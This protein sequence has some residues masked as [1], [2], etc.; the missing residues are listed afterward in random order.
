MVDFGYNRECFFFMIDPVKFATT[1]SDPA[2][3]DKLIEESLDVLYSIPVSASSRELLKKNMLLTGQEQN[4]YWTDAWNDL[5][6]NPGD[7][8]KRNIVETRLK[9]LY[10]F[11]LSS[12]EYQLA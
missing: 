8:S 2:D 1:L 11:M 7:Q 5:A 12:P 9:N 3:P 10:R 4:H 6:S